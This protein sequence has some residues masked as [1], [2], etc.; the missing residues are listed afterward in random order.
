MRTVSAILAGSGI[1]G[2]MSL[3]LAQSAAPPKPPK[4]ASMYFSDAQLHDIMQ[5]SAGSFSTRLFADT[6]F[7]SAFI[8]L[9][10]PD[11]PH[12]HGTWSEVFFIREGSGVLETGGAIT[13]VT[14]QDSATHRSMFV[15]AEGKAVEAPPPSTPRPPAPGDLAGTAI[16]GGHQ[17]RVKA[18]DFVLIPAGVAHRWLQIDQPIVYLDTKFPKSE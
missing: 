8:R 7:S 12:A 11:Q 13:G 4:D 17:Q 16:E 3:A 2:V 18:G 15:N 10:K 5:K 6:T 14:G 1:V 9:E